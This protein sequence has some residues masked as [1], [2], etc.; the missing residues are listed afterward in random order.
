MLDL[1]LLVSLSLQLRGQVSDSKGRTGQLI[2]LRG[3]LVD[4]VS[5]VCGREVFRSGLG[6][7]TI[8]MMPE[9]VGGSSRT[10]I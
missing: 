8:F 7:E 6:R 3:E 2:Y 10:Q 9:A 4:V 1:S 5:G